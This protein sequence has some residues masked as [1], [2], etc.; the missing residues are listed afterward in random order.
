MALSP[1]RGRGF[2]DMHSEMNRMFDEMF[3]GLARVGGRQQGE[4]PMQWAPALDVLHEDGD[5]VVRAELPGVQQEDVD[6][7]LHRGVKVT[8]TDPLRCVSS[9]ASPP[10]R[11]RETQAPSAGRARDGAAAGRGPV[12]GLHARRAP[13]AS[14]ANASGGRAIP[15]SCRLSANPW[16][17]PMS[18][19]SR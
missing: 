13:S 18:A 2:Y 6:I 17:S 7:T 4:R 19:E 3:G 16:F 8:R 12:R 15:V 5:V 11:S 9:I 1:F 10:N 14:A